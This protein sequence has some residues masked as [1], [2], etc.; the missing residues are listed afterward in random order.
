MRWDLASGTIIH[1]LKG[2]AA[3]VSSVAIASNGR[4]AM[5]GSYDDILRLW[6]LA[7]GENIHTFAGHT[8]AVTSV[9]I[10]PDRHTGL[11]GSQDMTLRLWD[12]ILTRHSA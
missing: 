1:T 11:S 7:S 5:S 8:G 2:H 4:T 12:L 10:A 3:A 9:A 6:D